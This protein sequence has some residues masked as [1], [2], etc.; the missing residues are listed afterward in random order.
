MSSMPNSPLPWAGEEEVSTEELVRRQGVKPIATLEDLEALGHPESWTS[1]E[2]YRD[3]LQ[4]LYASRR[5]DA[6]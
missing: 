3:F 2:E 6:S 4:D 1:D 5:T